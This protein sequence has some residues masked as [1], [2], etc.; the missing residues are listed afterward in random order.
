MNRRIPNQHPSTD[1]G[2]VR[3]ALIGEAGGADEEAQG[4]PFCG[5][6]GWAL[7]GWLAQAGVSRSSCFVGNVACCRPRD[8]DF[9]AFEWLGSEVQEGIA[10]LR[11][12]LARFRPHIIV[13]LGNAALHLM[14][15]GNEAPPKS[16]LRRLFQWPSR[17]G[18]WRGSLF[19]ASASFDPFEASE[20]RVLGP[21]PWREGARHFRGAAP[22][23][24]TTVRGAACIRPFSGSPALLESAP[25]AST[26]SPQLTGRVGPSESAVRETPRGEP[27]HVSANGAEAAS[28][29]EHSAPASLST[30]SPAPLPQ[31]VGSPPRPQPCPTAEAHEPTAGVRGAAS[32]NGAALLAFEEA[33]A[34][35]TAAAAPGYGTRPSPGARSEPLAV[36]PTANVGVVGTR[37]PGETVDDDRARELNQLHEGSKPSVGFPAYKVLSTYHPAATFREPS[38]VFPL[39]SDLKRAV[40][41]ARTPQ[42]VLPRRDVRYGLTAD[43]VEVRCSAIRERQQPVGFD[44]EGGLGGLQLASFAMSPSEAFVL[45]FMSGGADAPRLYRAM[46]GVLED[47]GVPKVCWNA[48]YERA[49]LEAVCSITL[50]N[51]EDGM[52]AWWER[53]SELPKGLDY[54]ASVLTR[55]PYWAEGIGWDARTG[56]PKVTGA[57][58]YTYNGIDSCV[59]LE[60]WEHAI[61][62]AQAEARTPVP[63]SL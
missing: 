17:V 26:L 10:A 56:R 3:I 4:M 22:E 62:R 15:H 9:N 44:I 50:T 55:E 48:S 12:D 60:I 19:V 47:P 33:R 23:A 11:D 21:T 31:A 20:L 52:L 30:L 59:T 34:S 36:A 46:A 49:I 28:G 45:D 41:E 8:N 25:C 2:A 13:A 24:N 38:F 14:R 39:V 42:L 32:P 54:V 29:G 1:P 5:K 58:F 51:Y 16:A 63:F 40:A 37:S 27:S 7:N 61:V 18:T 6:S 43:D 53:F 57:P 35:S